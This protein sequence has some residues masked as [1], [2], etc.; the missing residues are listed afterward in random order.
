[1]GRKTTCARCWPVSQS[2]VRT[3]R[4]LLALSTNTSASTALP[5]YTNERAW[6]ALPPQPALDSHLPVR[7]PLHTI[8]YTDA[9]ALP[10]S[11]PYSDI[12]SALLN[13]CFPDSHEIF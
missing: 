11:L 7:S 3:T 2:A 13:I 5:D 10:Y 8:T 9:G 4:I 12:T 1:M 6:C